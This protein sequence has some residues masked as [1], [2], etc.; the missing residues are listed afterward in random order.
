M[1]KPRKNGMMSPKEPKAR[2]CFLHERHIVTV[3]GEQG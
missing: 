2:G 1:D 3:R